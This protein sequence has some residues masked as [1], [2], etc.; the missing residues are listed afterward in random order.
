MD[1]S[2]A[3]AGMHHLSPLGASSLAYVPRGRDLY[4]WLALPHCVT[5]GRDEGVGEGE[6]RGRRERERERESSLLTIKDD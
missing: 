1:D 4:L 5:G 3:D 6:G 2:V